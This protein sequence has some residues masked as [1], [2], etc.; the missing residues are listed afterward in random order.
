MIASSKPSKR[1]PIVVLS[2]LLLLPSTVGS[3]AARARPGTL[4]GPQKRYLTALHKKIHPMWVGVVLARAERELGPRDPFNQPKRKAVL[5]LHFDA[6]G[7]IQSAKVR[8]SSGH[9]AFDATARSTVLGLYDFPRPPASARSDDGHVYVDWTF[10]RSRPWCH[11]LHA[12]I[13]KVPF[14]ETVL[15]RGRLGEAITLLAQAQ[16][17]GHLARYGHAFA[18]QLI[19]LAIRRRGSKVAA[20]LLQVLEAPQPL[21]V[22]RTVF[23][24]TL[25]DDQLRLALER[26]A[27]HATPETDR[28]LATLLDIHYP[29]HPPKAALLLDGM[30]QRPRALRHCRKKVEEA[31]TS[32]NPDAAA[33]AA[34]VLL[35]QPDDHPGKKQAER[36][37]LRLL[38]S[39][40][41][42]DIRAA[43]AR[44]DG[45]SDT[46]AVLKQL[47]KIALHPRRSVA[48]KAALAKTLGRVG[49]K[50]AGKVLL[51]LTY[52]KKS[53]IQIPALKALSSV[54]GPKLAR[55]YRMMALIKSRR[56]SAPTR[57]HAAACLARTCLTGFRAQIKR[58]ARRLS[59]PVRLGIAEG[60]PGDAPKAEKILLRLARSSRARIR[61]AALTNMLA[62]PRPAWR[63]ALRRA[64][65]KRPEAFARLQCRAPQ[66]LETRKR[67]FGAAQGPARLR[68]ARALLQ[69]APQTVFPWVLSHLRSKSWRRRL[70]AAYVL[71]ALP[72]S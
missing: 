62:H 1:I 14:T 58:A 60:L 67:C 3:G 20:P 68:L 46:P 63:R 51:M 13:P 64:Q 23:R 31:L 44:V 4:S 5:R 22:W 6:K 54:R 18:R 66:N 32:S 25:S 50:E 71:L 36:R 72:R 42:A 34:R 19:A 8:Q 12:R 65:R 27:T 41:P 7:D 57:R 48:L 16:R 17:K 38:E 40:R 70:Q 39:R 24:G 9:R 59:S 61:R 69:A 11:P 10:H 43:L 53:A 47:K 56:A 37:L 28:L 15:G 45:R 33:A 35:A 21:R 30:A 55:C 2:L 29:A 26:L 49:S 52:S